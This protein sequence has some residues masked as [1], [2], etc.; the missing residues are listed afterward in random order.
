MFLKPA[1]KALLA[2]SLSGAAHAIVVPGQG[3]Q[4]IAGQFDMA[5]QLERLH[6]LE[7]TMMA[8]QAAM[9]DE[10]D[11]AGS[12]GF[13]EDGVDT[14]DLHK[15]LPISY[16]KCYHI[17]SDRNEYL[18]HNIYEKLHFGGRGSS[19][20]FQICKN[21]SNCT[22]NQTNKVV[23]AGEEF[24]LYDINGNERRY[25]VQW[26][27]LLFPH[28]GLYTDIVHFRGHKECFGDNECAIRLQGKEDVA[29]Y[30]SL[31]INPI[32]KVLSISY[33]GSSPVL[34]FKETR[35]PF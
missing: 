12:P 3:Q 15:S 25:V 29:N 5:E 21:K 28:T 14:Y 18:G 17:I 33:T 35:C 13:P 30:N 6:Q 1:I 20:I 19:G 24:V 7:Q 23:Q 26:G 9:G 16:G 8:Q 2:L 27:T 10:G 22:P 34:E 32:S 4:E 31:F 11:E